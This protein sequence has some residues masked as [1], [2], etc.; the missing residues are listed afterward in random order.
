MLRCAAC[1]PKRTQRG[2]ELGIPRP[3]GLPQP[4]ER[5]VFCSLDGEAWSLLDEDRLC[6]LAVEEGRLDI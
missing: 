2:V 1:E 4:V 6:Q 3:W 5:L